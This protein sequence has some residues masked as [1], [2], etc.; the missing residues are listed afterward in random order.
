MDN[1]N[2]NIN[3]NTIETVKCLNCG[4]KFFTQLYI[5]KKVS[6]LQS[7]TGQEMFIPFP[8][9]A[10]LECGNL[11]DKIVDETEE[12]ENTLKLH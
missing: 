6:A 9:F 1:Q 3:T 12:D 11:F 2:I 8:V 7:P 5:M 4:H 10:C